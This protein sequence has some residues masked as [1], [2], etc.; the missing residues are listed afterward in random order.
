MTAKQRDIRNRLRELEDATGFLDLD[1]VIEAARDPKDLLHEHFTW[2]VEKAAYERW[3][4]QARALI[5]SVKYVE[6]TTQ[7]E[8]ACPKY[9]SITESSG[10]AGYRQLDTV[11]AKRDRSLEVF[12]DEI[13]RTL[14]ALERARAVSDVL[15][16]RAQLEDVIAQ[17][18]LIQQQAA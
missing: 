12:N 4:D 15:G 1:T 13:K 18:V 5:R 17:V 2:D 8:L 3:K 6:Q 16:L 10:R 7:H 11:K 14:A 9:I